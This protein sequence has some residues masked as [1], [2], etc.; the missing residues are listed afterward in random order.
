MSLCRRR[1]LPFF[2]YLNVLLSVLRTYI[3]IYIHS[4]TAAA[5][6]CMRFSF[7]TENIIYLKQHCRYR[8]DKRK[9]RIYYYYMHRYRAYILNVY[10]VLSLVLHSQKYFGGGHLYKTNVFRFHFRQPPSRILNGVMVV[11]YDLKIL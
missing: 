1:R 7:K 11:I 5:G 9:S 6:R 2:H 10:I 4:T 3:Y 8:A